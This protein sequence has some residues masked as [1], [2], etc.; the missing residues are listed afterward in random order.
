M[1]I[2]PSWYPEKYKADLDGVNVIGFR[3]NRDFANSTKNPKRPKIWAFG[4]KLKFPN[5][6][7]N[8]LRCDN[9]SIS[10]PILLIFYNNVLQSQVTRSTI[11]IPVFFLFY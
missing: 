5:F 2:Q 3:S 11:R 4:K 7:L 6:S 9:V 8:D 10:R 1:M